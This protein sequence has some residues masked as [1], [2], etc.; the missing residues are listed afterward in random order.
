MNP[1]VSIIVPIYDKE[2][3]LPRCIDSILRQSFTAFES[4][5][6]DDGST[7]GSGAICDLYA[8]KDNSIRVFH[9]ENEGSADTR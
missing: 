5:L 4:L 6:I 7:D 8:E 2:L 1:L 3:C 9:K